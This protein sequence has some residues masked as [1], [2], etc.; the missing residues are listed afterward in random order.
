MRNSG[1]AIRIVLALSLLPAGC[2]VGPEYVRPTPVET[3]MPATF[4]ELQGWK[5]AHPQSDTISERWW[6]IYNDPTLN[7]LEE[8]VAV[9]NLNVAAAEAQFRQARA[10]VQAAKAGYYPS[11]TV[12]ASATRSKSSG[13]ISTNSSGTTASNFQL[14]LDLT[15]ELDLWGRIRRGVEA[16][17][18]NAQASAADLAAATLSAQAALAGNYFQ[19]RVLDAQRQLLD[20]TTAV[21]RKSLDMTTNRYAAGVA[22]RSDVLQAETQLRSTEAQAID[23]GIQ[24]AQLEHA[25]ALLIGKPPAAFSLPATTLTAAVPAIPIGLPS[26]L[27]ERRP[28][29]ASSE[30]KMAA[31]NAQIGVA[32]AAY[33][34]TIQL[35]AAG[36]FSS[37]SLATWFAWPSRFWSIGP[38]ASATLFDGGLRSAQTDQARAAYDATVAAYRE[39]VL[40]G[41]Q[42]VEDNLAALR[43]LEDETRVQ[44]QAVKAAR[45]VVTITTNQYQAGTVAYLNVLVAQSTALANERTA[46]GLAG[47]RLAASVLLVKALGGGWIPKETK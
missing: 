24:R 18:A 4:K 22:A 35:S 28:D 39:T 27:L 9:S 44:D 25:I 31:A 38:S 30:R 32:Q 3:A 29:I 8:Q 6:E 45:Q 10:V 21:Y 7:A 12:G 16:G 17:Q 20:A 19:L 42:E 2:T 1:V 43:I 33:Y 26:E 46:L 40:T 34:P 11:L 13:H 41:F 37:S 15:W 23:L 5:V 36:G 47:Q 14:P